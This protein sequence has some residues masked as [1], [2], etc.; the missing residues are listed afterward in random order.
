MNLE[1]FISSLPG[2]KYGEKSPIGE[3]DFRSMCASGLDAEMA[4]SVS[5]ILDGV[6]AGETPASRWVEAWQAREAEIRAA[7]AR[8]RAKRLGRPDAGYGRAVA[9]T[10][11]APAVEAAFGETDPLRR[12]MAL[13][14]LRWMFAEEM[15]GVQPIAPTV[16]YAYAAKL[17]LVLRRQ[18]L[19][20]TAGAAKF[21]EMTPPNG[22][23]VKRS[24]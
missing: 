2:L 8:R 10:R 22:Q 14:R 17:R 15:E 19:D 1:Y 24:N 12:E 18:A 13:D 3:G 4:R 5:Q 20:E 23:T 7:V 9:D 6:A 21:K 16:V 11:I